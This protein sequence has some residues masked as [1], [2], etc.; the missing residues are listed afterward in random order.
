MKN[1]K[2]LGTIEDP[3]WQAEQ[4]AKQKIDHPKLYLCCGTEDNICYDSNRQFHAHLQ[5]IGFD[6]TYHE[7]PGGHDWDFWDSEI[8]QILNWLPLKH[9]L[10]DR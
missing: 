1:E 4:I 3:Y 2:L 6:H 8:Q 10:V 9:D 5:Q 7:Q